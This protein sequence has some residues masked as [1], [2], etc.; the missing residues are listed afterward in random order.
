M[1]V[2][3]C[4][5]A[6][7]HFVVQLCLTLCDPL[8]SSPPGYSVHGISSHAR[9]TGVGCHFPLQ[10][11]FLTHRSNPHLLCLLHCRQILYPMSHWI[12]LIYTCVCVCVCVC[13][14]IHTMEYYSAI[15]KNDIMP[16]VT[17]WKDIQ[18][19]MLSVTRQRQSLGSHLYV[20]CNKQ[21]KTDNL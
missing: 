15:E 11:I 18:G 9:N 7:T 16:F 5:C 10:G 12:S 14:C 8:D 21:N 1:C 2:Y 4:V 3:A 17:T 19:I 13:V 6:C 20:E